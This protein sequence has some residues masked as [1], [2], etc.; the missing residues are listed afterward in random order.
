MRHFN[1]DRRKQNRVT[2]M[3]THFCTHFFAFLHVS[4]S[5]SPKT[6]KWSD[7]GLNKFIVLQL[8]DFP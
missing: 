3:L 6:N 1:D 5:L 7:L 2:H 8:G 4:E